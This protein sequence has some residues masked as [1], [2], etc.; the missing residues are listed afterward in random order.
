M[1]RRRQKQIIDSKSL[2]GLLLIL[3]VIWLITK[4]PQ[5]IFLGVLAGGAITLSYLA[6]LYLRR[7]GARR[8]LFQKVEDSITQQLSP[9]IRR[10]AQLVQH[11]AYGKPQVDKWKKEIEY[12]ITHH[13][14]SSLSQNE[15]LVLSRERATVASRVDMR[16]NAAMRDDPAF[17]VFSNEMT[18]AQFEVFCAEELRRVGW[19][20]HVTTQSRDQGVDVVAEKDGVRVVLQCKLYSRPVGNKAV[21]EAAAARAHERAKYGIVVSNNSYTHD[22]EQLASTNGVLLLHYRD[23]QDLGNLLNK[24]FNAAGPK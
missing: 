9:L 2:P 10:R 23:L 4:L 5:Q 13:I 22:A 19:N 7:V 16:I 8:T 24:R 3:G 14:K 6:V 1:A 15:C 21:Q 11:D 18:P 17:Q 20:A 12:F